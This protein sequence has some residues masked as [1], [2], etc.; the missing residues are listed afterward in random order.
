MEKLGNKSP[1]KSKYCVALRACN[2][3]LF[4]SFHPLEKGTQESPPPPCPRPSV[5]WPPKDLS[6]RFTSPHLPCCLF[7]PCCL[8][9]F[10]GHL[11]NRLLCGC[12]PPHPHQLGQI[13]RRWLWRWRFFIALI[14]VLTVDLL[15]S[16]FKEW[17]PPPLHPSILECRDWICFSSSFCPLHLPQSEIGVWNVFWPRLCKHTHIS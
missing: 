9:L 17:L 13:P 4:Q 7:S 14:V 5:I 2:L 16:L 3:G 10:P 11:L 6:D 12:P 1:N 8:H 15:L